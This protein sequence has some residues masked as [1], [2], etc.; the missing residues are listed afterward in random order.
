MSS[1]KSIWNCLFSPRLIQIYGTGAEQMYEEDPLERWGNQIINSLYMMWKVG[2][3]TSPLWGS[4]LYNKGYFQLQELPFIAKCATGV[5]VILVISFCIRGLSRAKNPAYLKF[6]DVLQRAEN[7]MVATKPELMKYDFEFKSWPVEYDLSDTKSPTPKA[8]PRV[9]VPQGA[10]Q[11]IVSIPF[12]V[13][14]YLA[15]HTF[16]IRLI[17]PGVLGVLQAVLEKGLL[18]GRTRLIEV[19]AGQRYKL[20][21]VDGN[22]IDTMVLDRRSSYANGDTLVICCEGNAGFYEIGTV[23]TPIEAG[24][25]VI[26]WNHPG[27][28]GSTGMPYPAQEQNAIDAVIQFAINILGFKVE[29]IMLFGW[30]IGGYAVSWAAMTYPDIKS[31]VIDATFDDI[32]PLALSQMPSWLESIVKLAIREHANLDIYE[33]L[34]KYP[35]PVLL[36]R[37]TEDEVICIRP[38]DLSSNRCNNL[39]IKIFKTRYPCMCE[40]PQVQLLHEYLAVTG[41]LQEKILEKYSIDDSICTSLLQS[42]ISEFSK[43]Y[44]MKIGQDFSPT[45]KNQMILFLAKKYMKDFKATH[46][47]A[48]PW[49]MFAVPWDVNVEPDFVYT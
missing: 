16:G 21:T 45:E 14:A 18:K 5:G 24:Y 7:D 17:Y 33:Q 13:I 37:R 30:S 10:F 19:Y 43:S 35:G 31:V 3:C 23:I 36:I 2:L 1:L 20:K 11:N 28:G 47:V 27:F 39:L 15:I 22:S 9:A 26:G 4:A 25:S 12:R 49:D 6:L 8:S 29:N 44:P 48:L 41:V 32:M 34:S 46:C 40:L 42:Y 38:G